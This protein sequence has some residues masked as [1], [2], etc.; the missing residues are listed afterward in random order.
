MV[1]RVFLGFGDSDLEAVNLFL[2]TRISE[3]LGGVRE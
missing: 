3:L 1:Q 2:G